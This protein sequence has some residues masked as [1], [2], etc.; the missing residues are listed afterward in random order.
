M[1]LCSRI[2]EVINACKAPV[3]IYSGIQRNGRRQSLSSGRP[4]SVG[5]GVRPF[6]AW[7][8]PVKLGSA[9]CRALLAL[10]GST[11]GMPESPSLKM[12]SKKGAYLGET[13]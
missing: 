3:L 8:P 5:L 2:M 4:G 12:E 10:L 11:V 9:R 1:V 7:P 6:M 13:K